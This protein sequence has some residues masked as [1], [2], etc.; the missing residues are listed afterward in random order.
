LDLVS[1]PFVA[2]P[3]HAFSIEYWSGPTRLTGT[4][5]GTPVSGFG[6]DERTRVFCLD[7]EIVE[8]LRETLR[9]LPAA[10]LPAGRSDGARL[11]N[12]AWEIDGFIADGDQQAAVRYLNARV[13]PAI[14]ALAEPH[15]AHVRTIV[16]DAA[17]ALLRWWVRP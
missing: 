5:D 6:F 7:F 14:E 9:H 4:L 16:D 12:L 1:E 15:R 2:A 3:A 17:D 11:A 8:V 13:R 10:A